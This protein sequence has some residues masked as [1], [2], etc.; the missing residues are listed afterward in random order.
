[1]HESSLKKFIKPIQIGS[2][3]LSSNIF[4]S[5]LAGCSD[6]TYRQMANI[7]R[8]GLFFCEMVKIDA[9]IRND[10]SSYRILDYSK[11]MHPI[12]AQLCGSHAKDAR[13]GAQIIEDLGFDLLDL[14]CGCPVDKVTKDGSG[15]GML[16]DLDNIASVLSAMIGA[17]KIP[18]TLKIRVGW[19]DNSIVAPQITTLA[20]SLGAK[21]IFIHGRTREQKYQGLANRELIK[22]C[23]DVRKHIPVF[24]NGDIF[25]KE[26]A[27]DMFE[28][29]LCDGILVSR[30]TLGNP[31]IVKEIEGLPLDE[32]P[33]TLLKR[34]FDFIRRYHPEEQ[35]VV[36][37]RK[38]GSWYLKSG[39]KV[40]QLRERLNRAQSLHDID[41]ALEELE[42]D[43]TD[44]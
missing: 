5:P 6:F 12:G 33:L 2:L 25:C 11:E 26:S 4:Y 39:P 3:H 18:V 23:V 7:Y 42:N 20:E 27:E 29:T 37:M 15:S 31:A 40:K 8:P 35:V 13:I 17:V 43:T 24:G 16:K 41:L 38:I 22:S 34:H 19:D 36:E 21:A 1:M 14:N 9:L 10:A 32:S 44:L 28:K 30:G